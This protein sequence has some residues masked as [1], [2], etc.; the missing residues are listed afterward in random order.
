V[1]LDF[2]NEGVAIFVG[3]FKTGNGG[4][5]TTQHHLRRSESINRFKSVLALEKKTH[6]H[7]HRKGVRRGKRKVLAY[8]C[9]VVVTPQGPNRAE[10]WRDQ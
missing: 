4:G 10:S 6:T 7:P 5:P 8:F 2:A 3:P 9:L 1:T